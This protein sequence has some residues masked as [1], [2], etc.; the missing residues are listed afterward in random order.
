MLVSH[1][2]LSVQLLLIKSNQGIT[3]KEFVDFGSKGTKSIFLT[4]PKKDSNL[5]ST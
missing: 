5:N 1:H 2:V 4:F 3:A